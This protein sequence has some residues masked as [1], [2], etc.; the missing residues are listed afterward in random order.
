[1]FLKLKLGNL[2][3]KEVEINDIEIETKYSVEE[4]KES[5]AIFKKLISDIPEIIKLEQ[6]IYAPQQEVINS[7]S[8]STEE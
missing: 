8:S 5:Y 1:M 3:S 6:Q 7:S 2:K 4:M